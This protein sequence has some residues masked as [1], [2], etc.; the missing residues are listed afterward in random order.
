MAMYEGMRS[1]RQATAGSNRRR[2]IDLRSDTVTQPS[3]AMRRAMAEAEVGDDVYGEDPTVA[4]LEARAAEMLGKEAG[5]FVTSGTQSNLIALMSHCGRGEEFIAGE[6]YHIHHDEAGGAAVLASI[7]PCPLATDADGGLSVE[8]VTNAIKADD[9]HYAISRLVCLEN[10]V[11]GKVQ[12]QETI[13]AIAA[14]AHAR[15][16]SVH[17]DGARLMNAAVASKRSAADLVRNVD[18]VSLCLSK[19]LGTPVGSVLCGPRDFI[20]RAVR[21]RKML[22]GGM[23]QAGVLAACGLYALEHNIERLAEDHRRAGDLAK[24]L[25]GFAGLKVTHDPDHTN[26]LFVEPRPEDIGPLLDHLAAEGIVFG[27]RK[28]PIRLVTHLDISDEDVGAIIAA[29][30]DFYA[31]AAKSQAGSGG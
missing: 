5:L 31:G 27:G 9:P 2:S 23:R 30:G 3:A 24:G 14:L 25:A 15:G 1:N 8:A 10:T 19:G 13:D 16:L 11:S 12:K 29:V 18:T 21:A 17:L 7:V 28:P 26:M 22:G 20:K 4:A 6:N